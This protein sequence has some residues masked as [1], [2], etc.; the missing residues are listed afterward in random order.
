MNLLSDYQDETVQVNA[1]STKTRTTCPS[2]VPSSRHSATPAMTSCSSSSPGPC[3]TTRSM[4]K[5]LLTV[6]NPAW[7][8]EPSS[9]AG[10]SPR[11]TCQFL[12]AVPGAWIWTQ[13][14]VLQFFS[15]FLRDILSNQEFLVNSSASLFVF[16]GPKFTSSKSV[17]L[18]TAEG[19]SMVCSG[20]YIITLRF[21]YG[22]GSKFTPGCCNLLQY[23]FLSLGLILYNILTS[24]ST[25]TDAR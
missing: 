11:P 16:P 20:T 23:Q 3:C 24:S 10:G 12:Q 4:V 14:W 22:A 25:S 15:T 17:W 19:F 8:W 18:L 13:T 21:S 5:R 1:V 6:E 9:R 2:Q 7:S